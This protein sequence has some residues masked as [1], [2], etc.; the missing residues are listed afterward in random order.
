MPDNGLLPRFLF[1]YPVSMPYKW[2]G[3]EMDDEVLAEYCKLIESIIN[4]QEQAGEQDIPFSP[5]GKLLW[6]QWDRAYNTELDSS[7]LHPRMKGALGKLQ[8]Y[9]ARFALILEYLHAFQNC[10]IPSYI[11]VES[12]Q[13]AI[14]LNCYYGSHF[15]R[16]LESVT[17]APLERQI[18][19]LVRWFKRRKKQHH[20]A[21]T[22]EAL[23]NGAA[24]IKNSQEAISLFLELK[25]RGF[26]TVRTFSETE[27]SKTLQFTLA[28][29]YWP[30]PEEGGN[31]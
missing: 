1:S 29:Q 12:L 14:Q 9:T 31:K 30:K 26:G 22:R 21:T 24:N 6:D 8:A 13:K 2:T 5:E 11:G 10:Q 25:S 17:T 18:N 23:T 7:E 19:L 27:T 3:V 16:V 28:Q 15:A 4:H 20:T